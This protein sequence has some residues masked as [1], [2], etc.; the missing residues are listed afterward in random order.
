MYSMQAKVLLP[1]QTDLFKFTHPLKST[2]V[3]DVPLSMKNPSLDKCRS[4]I[5]E[6]MGKQEGTTFFKVMRLEWV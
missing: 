6:L 1:E 4:S 2:I 5:L 3:K